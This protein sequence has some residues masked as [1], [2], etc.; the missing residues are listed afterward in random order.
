MIHIINYFTL[1][2][3][4]DINILNVYSMKLKSMKKIDENTYKDSTMKI[5][6]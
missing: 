6:N 2:T 3:I 1:N 4:C 5:N